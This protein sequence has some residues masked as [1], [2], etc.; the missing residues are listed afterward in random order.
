MR[1]HSWSQLLEIDPMQG[2]SKEERRWL[3]DA[4]SETM[5]E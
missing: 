5:N 4:M 2:L 1:E 3:G